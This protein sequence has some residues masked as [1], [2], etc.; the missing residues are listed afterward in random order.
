[1]WS[2]AFLFSVAHYMLLRYKLSASP[3]KKY[4]YSVC[5]LL[6][7]C[8]VD[9]FALKSLNGFLTIF[10]AMVLL[11]IFLLK[12]YNYHATVTQGLYAFSVLTLLTIG[13]VFAV[14]H[15]D[16]KYSQGKL[17]NLASDVHFILNEDTSGAWKWDGSN[18]GRYPLNPSTNQ[19]VHGST[20]ERVAWYRQ[21][22]KFLNEHPF[23]LGYTSR[24]FMHY[25]SERFTG[26]RATKTHSGW[27]DFSLGAGVVGLLCIW[28][29]MGLIAIRVWRLISLK[30]PVRL[31]IFYVFWCLLM[32][33]IL[34]HIG[35]LSEREFIESFFFSIAFFSVVTEEDIG[36]DRMNHPFLIKQ[37]SI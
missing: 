3:N 19:V 34:W 24:A 11:I 25:M 29:A 7:I 33:F 6:P 13:F 31:V 21:G 32:M 37:S 18:D 10:F 16:A 23:G 36:K 17:N 28:A 15:F 20:Y 35:E 5:A 30:D 26:S 27:L 4:I 8:I 9:L 1:M 14:L 12:Q 2:L 22:L